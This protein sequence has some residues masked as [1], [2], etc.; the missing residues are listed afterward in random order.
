MQTKWEQFCL[1]L[2]GSY[3]YIWFVFFVSLPN[4]IKLLLFN[5]FFFGLFC[6]S[7][8]S[9]Q[10]IW[11]L[12]WVQPSHALHCLFG[13]NNAS[14]FL[15]NLLAYFIVQKSLESAL[16]LIVW[17][18]KA[19]R[20]IDKKKIRKRQLLF[21]WAGDVRTHVGLFSSGMF[22]AA[23]KQYFHEYCSN[24][25]DA[26]NKEYKI[27]SLRLLSPLELILYNFVSL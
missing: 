8:F 18:V 3:F 7:E 20:P 26:S 21:W 4:L 12:I 22:T 25:W 19:T 16:I 6:T 13:K 24:R 14:H 27:M 17:T 10:L 15:S 9:L 2:A 23:T 11:I 1:L 5:I